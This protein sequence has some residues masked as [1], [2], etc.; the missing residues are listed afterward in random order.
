[1]K[2][3]KQ[4]EQRKLEIRN[5][6]TGSEDIDVDALEQELTEL[7]AE[8]AKI[9]KREKLAKGLE[10]GVIGGEEPETRA[11]NKPGF[12]ELMNREVR[13]ITIGTSTGNSVITSDIGVSQ[14]VI[15]LPENASCILDFIGFKNMHGAESYRQVYQLTRAEAKYAGIPADKLTQLPGT[16]IL[17]DFV[18][19]PKKKFAL[20]TVFP[21]EYSKLTKSNYEATILN[22]IQR[23]VRVKLS[24]E[25]IVG[26][27]TDGIIGL[28]KVPTTKGIAKDVILTT[29]N[30]TTLDT[31]VYGFGSEEM[32]EANRMLI[33]NKATLKAFNDV[34]NS[35]KKK[36]YEIKLNAN[37]GCGTINGV[38]FVINSAMSNVADSDKA[39]NK[40]FLMYAE[41]NKYMLCEFA[42]PEFELSTDALFLNDMDAVKTTGFYGANMAGLNSLVRFAIK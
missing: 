3:R 24:H 25:V 38:P 18:E 8:L 33:M 1:M 28:A 19:I 37:G 5:L 30:D 12:T 7:D 15:G 26:D 10:A 13:S 34:K 21:K 6:L 40:Y 35:D 32:V 23:A 11:V 14:D 16:D 27:G 41:L 39:T 9:E 42:Q 4:I 29:I 31:I 36:L 2:T 17:F 22:E 20:S